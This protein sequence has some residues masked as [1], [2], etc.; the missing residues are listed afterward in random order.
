MKSSADSSVR[1]KTITNLIAERESSREWWPVR[2]H[3]KRPPRRCSGTIAKKK[4]CRKTILPPSAIVQ[5]R[6]KTARSWELSFSLSLSGGDY[7]TGN[8]LS[9]L[10]HGLG[11]PLSRA[12]HGLGILC[13][14]WTTVLSYRVYDRGPMGS[15]PPWF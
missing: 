13:L 4:R 9:G 14:V 3:E 15:L 7:D 12:V 11:R 6:R 8:R 10:N 1:R 5:Q 2:A